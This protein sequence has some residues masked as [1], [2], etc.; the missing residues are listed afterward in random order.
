[1]HSNQQWLEVIQRTPLVSIDLILRDEQGRVLLGLRTNRP[2]QNTWFVPG[3]VIRKNETL[4]QAFARIA[5]AEL[6]LT[7]TRGQAQ[8]KGVYQHFY[9]DNFAGEP[10]IPT[11]YVVLAYELIVPNL[12]AK[13]PLDQHRDLRLYTPDEVLSDPAVHQNTRAYFQQ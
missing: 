2:A 13:G 11:H 7:L 4:D 8:F 9:D 6:A 10:G 1:M 3:G 12:Q 5:E